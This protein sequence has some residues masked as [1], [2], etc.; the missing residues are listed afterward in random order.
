VRHLDNAHGRCLGRIHI[1]GRQRLRGLRAHL[2]VVSWNPH[3]WFGLIVVTRSCLLIF[4][5][6]LG[7]RVCERR[8]FVVFDGGIWLVR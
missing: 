6:E 7:K 1:G 3:L 5:I 2:L 4:G 8:W